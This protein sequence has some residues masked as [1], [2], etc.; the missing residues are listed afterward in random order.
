MIAL[1]SRRYILLIFTFWEELIRVRQES[2]PWF[3]RRL[4]EIRLFGCG[5]SG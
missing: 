3:L 5:G 2:E 4:E 1:T